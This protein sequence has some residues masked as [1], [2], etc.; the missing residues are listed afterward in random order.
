MK[1]LAPI[2][3]EAEKTYG[4]N[5]FVLAGIISWESSYNTSYR[6][7]VDNNVL[8][9]GVYGPSARGINAESKYDNIMNA[10]K[11]LREAYLSP[12]GIYFNGYSTWGLSRNYCRDE[13]GNPDDAWR[14]GVNAI[15]YE[16]LWVFNH[17]YR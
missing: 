14:V 5:A 12:N 10:A 9:W 8:G 3:I 4:I 15:S 17:L 11:F 1:E 6:A 13:Y 16:Y 2:I 7:Q